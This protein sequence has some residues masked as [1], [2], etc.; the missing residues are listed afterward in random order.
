MNINLK[1]LSFRQRWVSK[2]P[3]CILLFYLIY[4]PQKV[5]GESAFC[6]GRAA[7]PGVSVYSSRCICV[8]EWF[9]HFKAGYRI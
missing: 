1:V 2:W 3:P 6:A 4:T 9:S 5:F 8:L 7:A